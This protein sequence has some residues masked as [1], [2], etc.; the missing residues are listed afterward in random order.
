LQHLEA[1]PLPLETRAATVQKVEML[2]KNSQS[3][4]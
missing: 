1:A 4:H 3:H 2:L